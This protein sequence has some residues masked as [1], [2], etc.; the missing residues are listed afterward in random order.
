MLVLG[1]ALL[2]GA[3]GVA[4]AFA[5]APDVVTLPATAVGSHSAVLQG[6]VNPRDKSTSYSF[7]YGTTIWYGK[8]T[9]AASAGKGKA[10]VAAVYN[11]TG[12]QAGTTYHYRLVANSSDGISRGSDV[13]FSTTQDPLAPTAP[14]PATGETP[15]TPQPAAPPARPPAP[16][17]GKSVNVAP[18]LGT[19]TLRVPGSA[20]AV[21][22]HAA[23]SIPVGAMLDTRQG[24]S[25][26]RP[27]SPA[28]PH[29]ARRSTEGSSRS[30]R[31]H[32]ATA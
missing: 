16:V 29:R 4:A 23:G 14:S 1:V 9:P 20:S 31:R 5:R 25:I 10:D 24:S 13:S 17:L 27:R 32:R 7:E 22:L 28:A 11:L 15:P 19:V 3:F 30:A 26:S 21:P 8:F 2:A 12:L 18:A 6:T